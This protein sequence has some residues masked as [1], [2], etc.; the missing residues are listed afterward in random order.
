M[1][2]Y[3]GNFMQDLIARSGVGE[4]YL[5]SVFLE[6]MCEFL[7]EQAVLKNYT[8]VQYKKSGV[9]G[10]P[11]I[12]LDAYDYNSETQVLYVIVSDFKF[13]SELEVGKLTNTDIGKSF[14][15]VERFIDKCRNHDFFKTQDESTPGYY[16]ARF[17]S[18]RLHKISRV[19]FILISN[20]LLSKS[21]KDVSTLN[22]N[23]LYEI[24]DIG[25]I[26]RIAES[27]KSREDL[28]VDFDR[29]IP[30]LSVFTGSEK[31]KSYLFAFPGNV[32]TTL[33]DQY[34]ERLLE[35]NVRTFLQ[36]R[37]S[38]NKGIRNTI[39]NEPDMFFAYNNGITATAE[40][41]DF[42]ALTNSL[43]SITNFQIVNGG[44]TTASLFAAKRKHGYDLSK[45]F[46]Q[47]KLSVISTDLVEAIVPRISQYANTQNKVNLADFFSNHPFHLQIEQLSRRLWAPSR[48][49]QETHWFYERTRGQ[50]STAYAYLSAS[51]QREFFRMN[52]KHQVV[53]KTDLAKYI[54]S[55]DQKPNI[56]SKGAQYCFAHFA[57]D[58]GKKWDKNLHVYNEMYFKEIIA[59]AIVFKY[60]DKQIMAQPWYGG[61]KANIVT[62][63]IAKFVHCVEASGYFLDYKKIWQSQA[64]SQAMNSMLLK[65]AGLVNKEIQNTDANVTQY[66][67]QEL[68]WQNV[69]KLDIRLDSAVY[70]DLQDKDSYQRDVSKQI[71]MSKKDKKVEAVVYVFKK[72]RSYWKS[73][74]AWNSSSRVLTDKERHVIEFLASR[75]DF[76]PTEAQAQIVVRA[77]DRSLSEGFYEK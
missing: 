1:K 28:I 43:K 18:E 24:W 8:I 37:G 75:S 64:V 52:P 69:R 26:A 50:Y 25:R 7:V 39:Q 48:G 41:I 35:H 46:V 14:V 56:V 74:L 47:V 53:S 61:Y 22:D 30:C 36:F 10:I 66:C 59:K 19:Q 23:R 9:N 15:Q 42:D 70:D 13:S 29:P 34:G 6:W 77:E 5:E 49:M 38:V 27:G 11:A 57:N 4:N 32:L 67:K 2:D 68:C 20:G 17:I 40:S 63:S 65:I 54:Y 3:Y 62:Y 58:I 33:Y 44:Q 76:V 51:K 31:C 12:R 73:M 21:V 72:G 55:F 71:D 45:V 16:A 60:L